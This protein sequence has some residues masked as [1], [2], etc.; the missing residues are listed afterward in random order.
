MKETV[1]I[2]GASG[3]IGRH[4]VRALDGKGIPYVNLVRPEKVRHRDAEIAFDLNDP[5]ALDKERLRSASVMVHAA[6]LVH[7]GKFGE[8]EHMRRNFEATKVLFDMCSEVGIEHFVFLSTV[9]VYG[10]N[11]SDVIVGPEDGENPRTPYAKSKHRAED[12][13][14]SRDLTESIK[15]TII[16]L[17]LVYGLGAPGNFGLI[18]RISRLPLP[19]PL[20]NANNRRSMAS[21]TNVA[22]FILHCMEHAQY[23]NR[24]ILFCDGSVFSTRHIVSSIR[25]AMHRPKMLFPFHKS[26]MRVILSFLGKE[27]VYDQLYGDLVFERSREISLT[28]WSPVHS[29]DPAH[30]IRARKD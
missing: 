25:E 17:P 18:D 12:Y 21:A 23:Y 28:G 9:A 16:R 10:L 8:A 19:L 3:F 22:D 6:A 20:H 2:T 11:C 14:R 26:T 27:R 5:E 15:V 7:R 29:A 24:T 4:L 1:A 30:H 13:I